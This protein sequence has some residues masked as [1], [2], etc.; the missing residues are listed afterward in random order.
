MAKH[1]TP[2]QIEDPYCYCIAVLVNNVARDLPVKIS[3][4]ALVAGIDGDAST[5]R[6]MYAY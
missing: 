3:E 1:E 6:Y 4:T 5:A 2:Y